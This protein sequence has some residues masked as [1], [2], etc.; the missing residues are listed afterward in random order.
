[1]QPPQPR[2]AARRN[3]LDAD[4]RPAIITSE[5]GPR[6]TAR[7]KLVSLSRRLTNKANRARSF[8]RDGK[9]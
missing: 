7:Q 3:D 6:L 5:E 1:V 8:C 4:Q 9:L 2:A